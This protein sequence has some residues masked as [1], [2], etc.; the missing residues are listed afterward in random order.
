MRRLRNSSRREAVRNGRVS[1]CRF[2]DIKLLGEFNAP[3]GE[4]P[5]IID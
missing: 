1:D 4:I 2:R 5:Q 3:V